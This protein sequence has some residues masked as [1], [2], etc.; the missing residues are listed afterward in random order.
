MFKVIHCRWAFAQWATASRE[1][2]STHGAAHLR[3]GKKGKEKRNAFN[4]STFQNIHCE[5]SA[6]DGAL[7]FHAWQK[8][9][10][11]LSGEKKQK[12]L[13]LTC[14][15]THIYT[16]YVTKK[17]STHCRRRTVCPSPPAP[18][19]QPQFSS[20]HSCHCD[21]AEPFN[22]NLIVFVSL[23]TQQRAVTCETRKGRL[24]TVKKKKNNTKRDTK[25]EHTH[26][27]TPWTCF[28]LA[29]WVSRP[30][31]LHHPS[32]PG[33]RHGPGLSARL[34]QESDFMMSVRFVL[35]MSILWEDRLQVCVCC[36]FKDN[37]GFG[38]EGSH[39]YFWPW[40]E[41]EEIREV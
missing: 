29:S 9:R 28:C 1:L 6:S 37:S 20:C 31:S 22:S 18:Q 16:R 40:V 35:S 2:Q 30:Q 23:L 34:L 15:Y 27:H 17:A 33:S 4:Q 11:C 8:A 3:G 26:T 25:L 5:T 36:I 39:T 24:L 19:L 12:P 32:H 21:P 41:K 7:S 10:F 13:L 14:I 38:E